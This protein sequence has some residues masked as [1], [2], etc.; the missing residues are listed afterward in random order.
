MDTRKIG[1]YSWTLLRCLEDTGSSD[2]SVYLEDDVPLLGID[3]T[4]HHWLST[5]TLLTAGGQVNCHQ[6]WLELQVVGFNG[7]PISSSSF[8]ICVVMPGKSR[9]RTRLSG[10]KLHNTLFV[11]SAPDHTGNLHV[12][13][14]K[15]GPV[16]KLPAV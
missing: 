15:G 13:E 9:H 3:E 2:F 16:R 4:Y 12:A 5:I 6:V 14:K 1:G 10:H 7:Q 8:E 11:G